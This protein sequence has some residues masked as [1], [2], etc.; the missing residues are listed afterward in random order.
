MQLTLIKNQDKS[1]YIPYKI[2]RIVYAETHAKSLRVVEA[3][4]SMIQNFA[5][6]TGYSFDDILNDN[7]LFESLNE[8]SVNNKLIYVEPTN[9]GFQMCLRVAMR[10]IHGK[11]PDCCCGATRFHRD[12]CIPLWA[13]SRGYI[14]DIDGLLFYL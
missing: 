11:L 3:L 6:V 14:A 5:T 13:T 7:S 4:T 2:A 10:M 12:D 1:K 8:N 9:R